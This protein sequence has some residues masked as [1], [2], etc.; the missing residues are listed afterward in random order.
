[1]KCIFHYES[2]HTL[3]Y[4]GLKENWKLFLLKQPKKLFLFKRFIVFCFYRQAVCV[5]R[6]KGIY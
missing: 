5:P 6:Q 4:E 2:P 1:M 3:G